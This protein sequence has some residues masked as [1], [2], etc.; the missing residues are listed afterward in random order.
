M[1]AFRG[2]SSTNYILTYLGRRLWLL[3]RHECFQ[4]FL[5]AGW[6]DFR[7]VKWL[8]I[9]DDPETTLKVT[10]ELLAF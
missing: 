2:L 8:E 7:I 3:F 6:D 1:G 4:F 5:L 9:I 10:Q